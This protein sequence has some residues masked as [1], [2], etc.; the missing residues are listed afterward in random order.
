MS[1]TIKKKQALS[2]FDE[3]KLASGGVSAYGEFNPMLAAE[4]V[5]GKVKY[6]II[7]TPKH[8]GVRG[9]NQGGAMV[10]RSLKPIPNAHTRGLFKGLMFSGLDGELVVG[11]P[12][13]EEVFVISTSG[14]MTQLG[15]PDVT[16]F[17]FDVYHPTLPY[18]ERL[19]LRDHIVEAG[20]NPRI[21][22]IPW[23][24]LHNDEELVKCA[25]SALATGFEGLVLRDPKAK[26]KTGRSTALEGGFMR[27]C[28]WFRSEARVTAIHEG[29]VNQNESKRNELGYL[30]KSSH[31]DN[32]VGSGRAG[33]VDVVDLKT[34]IGFS[35]PVPTVKLQQA[36]W[37]NPGDYMLKIVK[38][39]FKPAVKVG[40]K[41]RFPQWEGLRSPLD[42]S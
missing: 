7:A 35:M 24:I 10:A 6:P 14:V 18:V 29:E 31:K 40:G 17:V 39:K 2:L 28:P 42:M 15:F 12:F 23:E 36:M 8:N 22:L 37:E 13:D 5:I 41:P 16:W 20:K 32:K 25:D 1:V 26:Y 33:S 11:D 38:Y 19:R 4:A 30:K 34:G 3:F 9:L 27:F 21:Q